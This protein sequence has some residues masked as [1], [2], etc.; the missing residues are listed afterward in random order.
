MKGANATLAAARR[1]AELV[2]T[3]NKGHALARVAEAVPR[4]G[5][6]AGAKTILAAAQ[7]AADA[8]PLGSGGGLMSPGAERRRMQSDVAKA[9]AKL[10]VRDPKVVALLDLLDEDGFGPG[11]ALNSRVFLDLPRHLKSLPPSKRPHE[12]FD[13][14]DQVA[15]TI[16]KARDAVQQL[17]SAQLRI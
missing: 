7:K 12:V 17:L 10:G 3:D 1:T 9:H 14:L 5:D 15:E 6:L 16:L 11:P 8:V 13:G 4:T 2:D